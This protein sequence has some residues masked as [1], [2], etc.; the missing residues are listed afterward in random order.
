MVEHA[1]IDDGGLHGAVVPGG[2]HH[3][4]SVVEGDEAGEGPLWRQ[5]RNSRGEADE[6]FDGYGLWTADRVDRLADGQ[7]RA[8]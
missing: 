2:R 5:E 6:V 4:Q 3:H 1:G 7:L 8:P